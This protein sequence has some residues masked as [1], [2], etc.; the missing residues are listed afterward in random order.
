MGGPPGHRSQVTLRRQVTGDRADKHT[1]ASVVLSNELHLGGH[2]QGI[3]DQLIGGGIYQ[4]SGQGWPEI[5][6]QLTIS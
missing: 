3:Q 5:C 6:H 2:S 4:R 1:A